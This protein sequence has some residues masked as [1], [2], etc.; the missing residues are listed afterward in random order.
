MAIHRHI[1]VY[2]VTIGGLKSDEGQG[3]SR[4]R[5]RKKGIF[6]LRAKV[7]EGGYITNCFDV[8]VNYG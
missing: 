4:G 6:R 8:S 3:I 7:G 1:G 2:E 5:R